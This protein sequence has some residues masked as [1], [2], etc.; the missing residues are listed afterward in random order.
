M[1]GGLVGTL[2]LR[3]LESLYGSTVLARLT[4]AG[5][6]YDFTRYR[7]TTRFKRRNI[8]SKHASVIY[9]L[10][11][12]SRQCYTLITKGGQADGRNFKEPDYPL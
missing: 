11:M 7:P 2:V 12:K 6:F 10:A 3:N 9:D 8:C 5:S 1:G 4:R